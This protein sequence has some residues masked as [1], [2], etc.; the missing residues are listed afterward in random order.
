VTFTPRYGWQRDPD[1]YAGSGR[2]EFTFGLNTA[3]AAYTQE[4][5]GIL[6]QSDN[7]CVANAIATAWRDRMLLQRTLQPRMPSRRWIYWYA[8]KLVGKEALDEGSQPSVA[9]EAINTLGC[10]AEE[11]SPYATSVFDEPSVEAARYAY[12]Q[13]GKAKLHPLFGVDDTKLALAHDL[14]VSV[15]T[16]VDAAFEHLAAGAVWPGMTGPM[17]GGHMFRLIGYDDSRE[18]FV[19]LNSWGDTWADRGTGLLSYRAVEAVEAMLAF[20]WAPSFSEDNPL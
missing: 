20:D 17:A 2:P 9:E 8:R 3:L 14:T 16:L 11:H 15:A 6:W 5:G 1:D 7:D 13:R 18:A 4:H 10:P 19:I 12:D